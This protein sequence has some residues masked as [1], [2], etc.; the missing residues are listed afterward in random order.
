MTSREVRE[1][2]AS[3]D[4]GEGAKNRFAKVFGVLED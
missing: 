3:R 2:A 4:S 1:S